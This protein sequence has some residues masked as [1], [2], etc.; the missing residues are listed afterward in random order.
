LLLLL[1]AAACCCY[2]LLLLAAAT[3]CCCLLLLAGWLACAATAGSLHSMQIRCLTSQLLIPR[4]RR[5]TLEISRLNVPQSAGPILFILH[6]F[7]RM[8]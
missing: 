5:I 1:A 8:M 3:C 7:L 2:L 6:F 4:N